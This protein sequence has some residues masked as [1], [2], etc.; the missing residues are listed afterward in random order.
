MRDN[1]IW[2]QVETQLLNAIRSGTYPVGSTLPTEAE[3]QAL[4]ECSRHT[5][6]TALE[7]LT[8]QGYIVRR[9]RIGSVVKHNGTHRKQQLVIPSSSTFLPTCSGLTLKFVDDS[10]ITADKTLAGLLGLP[11][12][13]ALFC[14]S[15]IQYAVMSGDSWPTKA[16]LKYYVPVNNAESSLA[17]N[18][19][20]AL[21]QA[22]SWSTPFPED[23]LTDELNVPYAKVHN[24]VT[25]EPA[26]ELEQNDAD[27]AVLQMVR[28]FVDDGDR[29]LMV[30]LSRHYGGLELNFTTESVTS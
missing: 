7:H 18:L 22:R 10:F 26:Q 5:V 27:G 25:I 16:R 4:F 21:R 15:Y 8:H 13:T 24:H 3:L 19:A 17:D 6:R 20:R 30:C 9:P 2:L 1:L 11:I 14:F 12:G 28:R 23:I 29:T